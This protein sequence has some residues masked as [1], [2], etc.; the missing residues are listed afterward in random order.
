MG[1]FDTIRVTC[2]HCNQ[3]T[4]EQYKAF[5]C[6]LQVIDLD[7]PIPSR[8][9]A[10]LEGVWKCS[11]CRNKFYVNAGL[12]TFIKVGVSKEVPE[13]EGGQNETI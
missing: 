3:V 2:P 5:D 13:E 6:T 7:Q 10:W 4:E 11:E 12:P 1:M 9:A 8:I